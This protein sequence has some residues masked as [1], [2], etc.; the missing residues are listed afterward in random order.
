MNL[1]KGFRYAATYSGI[2]KTMNDDVALIVSDEPATA[3]QK[4]CDGSIQMMT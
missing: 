4:Y 3:V 1:P 2:R